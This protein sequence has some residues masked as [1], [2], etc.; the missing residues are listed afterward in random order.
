[1]TEFHH[2][3]DH[4]K[5]GGMYLCGSLQSAIQLYKVLYN[6][7]SGKWTGRKLLSGENFMVLGHY[8][9]SEHLKVWTER[10]EIGYIFIPFYDR[11]QYHTD[12]PCLERNDE[13][14]P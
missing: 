2:I 9:D 8:P 14:T 5:I 4:F 3:Y 13:T 7:C 10:Q 1:M 6:D 12:F 11:D